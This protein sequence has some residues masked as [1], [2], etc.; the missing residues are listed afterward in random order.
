MS[1]DLRET[2]I[3]ALKDPERYE[4]YFAERNLTEVLQARNEPII[5]F[6]ED[7][8]MLGTADHNRPLYVTAESDG[9]MISR[10][11]ID[12]GSSVNLMSL[13]ALR[14]LCLD[15]EHLGQD[16]LMVHGFNEKGQKT[17]GSFMLPGE[18]QNS[19]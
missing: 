18:L 4:A 2:L 10:I 14:S 16:K 3:Q 6:A 9:M 12:P 11:L 13:K 17:L 19:M 7:D 1:K 15:V 8:L 5:T